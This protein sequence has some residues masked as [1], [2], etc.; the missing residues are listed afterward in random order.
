MGIKKLCLLTIAERGEGFGSINSGYVNEDPDPYPYKKTYGSGTFSPLLF[1]KKKLIFL[2][3]RYYFILLFFVFI[4][5][6]SI[7]L[8]LPHFPLLLFLF[9]PLYTQYPLFGNKIKQYYLAIKCRGAEITFI[10]VG[11]KV[12]NCK[13]RTI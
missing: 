1:I 8:F 3:Q 9:P 12:M 10:G 6:I 5:S 11:L 13:G 4:F 7:F 2:L